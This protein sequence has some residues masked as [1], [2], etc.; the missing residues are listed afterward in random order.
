MKILK[1]LLGLILGLLLLVVIGGVVAT[2]VID[3]EA[4]K[5][6]LVTRFEEKTGHSLRIDGPLKLFLF[7]RVGVELSGL[8][9]GN[10]PGFDDQPLARVE[11]LDVKIGFKPLLQKRVVVDTV[12]LNG[13][14]L[15]LQKSEQGDGNWEFLAGTEKKS[16]QA[17]E[18]TKKTAANDFSVELKGLELE[19][20]DLYFVDRQAGV[21][22]RLNDLSLKIGEMVAGKVVPL[23][24]ALKVE[25][26]QPVMKMALA[27]ST[28][29]TYSGGFQQ[30]EFSALSLA[31]DAEGEGLPGRGVKLNM[32]ADVLVDQAKG[33][34]VVSG[35]S[36]SGL[37]MDV[38][39]AVSVSG[40][41]TKPK[42]DG[43]LVLQQTNLKELLELTGTVVETTDPQALTRVSGEI[44][45]LQQGDSLMLKPIT[46]KLDD[47]SIEAEVQLLSFDGPVVRGDLKLDVIDLDRYL[48]PAS[49]AASSPA[50]KTAAGDALG[51]PDYES[52]RKLDLDIDF[53]IGKLKVNNLRM[54]K[55]LLKMRAKNGVVD[56]APLQAALY[57]GK[58]LAS[59]QLDVRKDLPRIRAKESLEG[60]QIGPLLKDLTGDDQLTG[61]GNVQLDLNTRGLDEGV[62]RRNLNGSFSFEFRDG[63]YKGFNLAHTIR[64]AQAAVS[65]KGI[66]DNAP[67]QTDFAELRASGLIKQGVVSN[68]DLYLASPVLRV[69][70]EGKVDLVKERVNYLVTARVVDTLKGQ[71]AKDYENLR[72]VAIPVRIKGDLGSPSPSVDIE[73]ALKAN[74]EQQLEQE[75]QKWQ[76][77][78]TKKL[79]EKLGT[80][81]LKGLFG[82]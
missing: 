45:L 20:L 65:G 18:K 3:Q 41:H 81:V 54:E 53:R 63:A 25:T 37:N 77:K 6:Q 49:E 12:V 28:G 71:G 15:N 4:L 22:H 35:F 43:K 24:A 50:G 67:Q 1:W 55:V 59:I 11:T 31:L 36:L 17:H 13:V 2:Y 75:K 66:P 48:P 42:V 34:L 60:I 14:T 19:D 38:N 52:L 32:A 21:E 9:L 82:R 26:S 61:T 39:G 16:D 33:S 7:P 80:D 76:E 5:S 58:F 40:I 72:G 10:A 64:Q 68:R 51:K 73:A 27:M 79:E 23:Q 74:A 70:G 78:A 56:L 62:I 46:L 30:I 8:V 47:S 44:H 57:G 69:K 29:L